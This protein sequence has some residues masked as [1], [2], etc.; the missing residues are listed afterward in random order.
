[1]FPPPKFSSNHR[2]SYQLLSCS[3]Q[4]CRWK[5]SSMFQQISRPFCNPWKFFPLYPQQQS[6]Q[7]LWVQHSSSVGAECGRFKGTVLFF[8]NAIGANHSLQRHI[9]NCWN[10][11]SCEFFPFHPLILIRDIVVAIVL[12]SKLHVYLSKLIFK[13]GNFIQN[14]QY[15]SLL[16][17]N[18]KCFSGSR[19]VT[20]YGGP[21]RPKMTYLFSAWLWAVIL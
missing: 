19:D 18:I 3:R 7:R 9:T 21:N 1:M 12:Y 20:L 6:V 13:H 5:S 16:Q 4:N 11:S 8:S 10:P 17:F 14:K 15:F 2:R